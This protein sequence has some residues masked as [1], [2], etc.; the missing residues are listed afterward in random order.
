MEN[1]NLPITN[2]VLQGGGVKGIAYVGALEILDELA[3][4][5]KI[6]NVAGTSAGAITACLISLRYTSSDI[7]NIVFRLTIMFCNTLHYYRTQKK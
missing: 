5:D 4:L 6:E 3:M 1:T 7:K 2:L